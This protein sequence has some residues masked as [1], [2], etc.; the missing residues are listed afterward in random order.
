MPAFNPWRNVRGLPASVWIIAATSFVN[1]AGTMVLPFMVL[2]VTKQLGVAVAMAGLSLT[3]YGIG[4]IVSAPVM[5]RLCDRLGPL[6]VLRLTLWCSGLMLF[7]FPFVKTFHTALWL[8]FV[9]AF[10]IEGVRPATLSAVTSS[11]GSEQRKA[12]VA[13]N[14]LAINLGMSIGPAVGGFLAAHSFRLLFVADGVTSL[15]AGLVLT[16]LLAWR[17]ESHHLAATA[18]RVDAAAAAH[19][20]GARKAILHDRGALVFFTAML[21]TSMVFLQGEGAMPVYLVRDL[22]F[23]ESFYGLLFVVNTLMIVAIE[24]PLNGIMERWPH[25]RAMVLGALLFAIGFG[26]LGLISSYAGVIAITVVWT[27]GEMVLFP[28][29]GAHV[30]DI[31]PP[32]WIG[33]YM[34]MYSMTFSIAMVLGPWAGT[35]LLDHLGPSIMWAIAFGVGVLAAATMALLPRIGRAR[36]PV[37]EAAAG[38]L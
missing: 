17:G 6:V 18:R 30:G 5:G 36:E 3:V 1:R 12:A 35:A 13:L 7:A 38:S 37:A 28:S 20:S 9:W 23:S 14:R 32:G 31:A 21:L 11:V 34:G 22:H 29:S 8:T 19:A 27:F 4:G 24:V 26:A 33:E 16:A 15:A 10:V 2:Y 25:W